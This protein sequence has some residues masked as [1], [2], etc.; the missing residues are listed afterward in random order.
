MSSKQEIIRK[1]KHK[2]RADKYELDHSFDLLWNIFQAA[3]AS[4]PCKQV[5]IVIDAI[6]ECDDLLRQRLLDKIFDSLR[7]HSN[8]DGQSHVVKYLISCQRTAYRPS[9]LRAPHIKHLHLEIETRPEF[10][11]DLERYLECRTRNLVEDGLCSFQSAAFIHR[12]LAELA[13]ASFLW[14]RVVLNEIEHSL[15]PRY[16]EGDIER[17][18]TDLPLSLSDAYSKYL[19][20]VPDKDLMLLK[21]YLQLTVMSTRPLTIFEI[22]AFTNLERH[23]LGSSLAPDQVQAT[24]S[25]L[26]KAFGPLIQFSN[27]SAKL[28]HP[29]VRE[30]LLKIGS[31]PHHTLHQSHKV[32]HDTAHG[33]FAVAC[34]RYLQDQRIPSNLFVPH[35]PDQISLADSPKASHW[36]ENRQ[37]EVFDVDSSSAQDHGLD[38][39]FGIA[40]VVFFQDEEVVLERC[41]EDIRRRLPAFDYA[42]M[43]WTYHYARCDSITAE[44][45]K[46]DSIALLSLE[47]ESLSNWY[48]YSV[49]QARTDMPPTHDGI[50]RASFFNLPGAVQALLRRDN[51]SP[52][53]IR[54]HDALYWASFSGSRDCVAILLQAGVLTQNP[55]STKVPLAVATRG[56]FLDICNLLLGMAD[57]N[58]NACDE[59]GQPPLTIAA[60]QNH[61]DILT[62]LLAHEQI[63][64]NKE[65]FGGRTALA[66]A[67][68]CSALESLEILLKDGRLDLN[69]KDGRGRTAIHHVSIAGDDRVLERLLAEVD[70]DITAE[71]SLGRNAVSLAAENGHLAVIKRLH[72]K[73]VDIASKDK[74]GRNAVSWAA[75]QR[76]A[77]VR[78]GSTE[79]VLE[80]MARRRHDCLDEPDEDGWS[81]L[82]WTLDPPG[83][84]Q[85]ARVLIAS[86]H[87]DVNRRDKTGRSILEWA[88]GEGLVDIVKILLTAPG[89]QKTSLTPSGGCPL[90]SA[91]ASGKIAVVKVLLEDPEVDVSV[92]DERGMSPADW[93]RLNN[94]SDVVAL[95]QTRR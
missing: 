91:A 30:F 95:L 80:F 2:F 52:N 3:L 53:E 42:A 9:W 8:L 77:A 81:P 93:A 82:A 65:D 48:R 5:Y 26:S 28:I 87:V 63:S 36:S 29:S 79:S 58:P 88:A 22:D 33:F 85:A 44:E 47:T 90:R 23:P 89:I 70:V 35:S 21:Q 38:D 40:D 75:N 32:S 72:R 69:A 56:G 54:L 76:K 27:I 14:L 16:A 25:S 61:T 64:C 71:D 67:C 41:C 4:I 49:K 18:M 73:S 50:V 11:N 12:R 19:P 6:D 94:H 46:G 45:L 51:P 60:K 10:A 78:S 55:G 13:G 31:N 17:L 59:S 39:L 86:G 57:V 83:F 92:R 7:T 68:R 66:V 37:A 1:I 62:V 20:K 15:I 84:T 24:K 74:K 34:I 43:N